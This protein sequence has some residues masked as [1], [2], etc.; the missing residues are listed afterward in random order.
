M[1][2]VTL[3]GRLVENAIVRGKQTKALVFTLA[4]KHNSNG[5]QK[6][7]VVNHVP[8]VMFN[9][10]PLVERSLTTAGK[11]LLCEFQGRLNSSKY[12]YEEKPRYSLEVVVF[13]KTFMSYAVAPIS[14]ACPVEG[15][16]NQT[17]G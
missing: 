3:V 11:N 14:P 5:D 8:C 2:N 9:P 7:Q 6:D 13:N 12:E 1:N 4:V 15:G 16:A 17:L 10:E